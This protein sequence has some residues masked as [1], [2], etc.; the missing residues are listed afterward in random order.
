MD[1]KGLA[2]SESL[3]LVFARKYPT[4]VIHHNEGNSGIYHHN[5]ALPL[6]YVSGLNTRPNECTITPSI[7]ILGVSF[8]PHG[9]KAILG[10][11]TCEIVNELPD[12]TNFIN[13]NY[14]E[15]LLESTSASEKI[16]IHCDLFTKQLAANNAKHPCIDKKAWD[17]ILRG[18]DE[19]AVL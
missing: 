14:V 5:R 18:T 9:L 7:S 17:L 10:L 16:E 1:S 3:F 4:L 8:H 6:G 2:K 13:K 19:T 12:I 15:R 11:D